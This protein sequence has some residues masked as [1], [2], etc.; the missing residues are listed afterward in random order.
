MYVRT[1][2]FAQALEALLHLPQRVARLV[3]LPVEGVGPVGD[4]VR[5]CWVIG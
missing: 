3:Q 4:L 5:C 1:E 2:R